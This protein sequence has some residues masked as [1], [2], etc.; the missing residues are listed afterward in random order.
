MKKLMTALTLVA[1]VSLS[2]ISSPVAAA[3]KTDPISPLPL[4][5]ML[6]NDSKVETHYIVS[7]KPLDGENKILV[8]S[9]QGSVLITSIY[10]EGDERSKKG[11]YCYDSIIP[12]KEIRE[13]YKKYGIPAADL[14]VLFQQQEMKNTEKIH[15]SSKTSR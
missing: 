8:I 11:M 10:E 5:K 15:K 3:E 2:V 6:S 13:Y 7:L 14:Y 12:R 9:L 1:I 4:L